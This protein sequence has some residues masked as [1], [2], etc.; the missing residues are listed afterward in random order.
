[1]SSARRYTFPAIAAAAALVAVS[2]V[3]YVVGGSDDDDTSAPL[4]SEPASSMQ[5]TGTTGPSETSTTATG[6]PPPPFVGRGELVA[7]VHDGAWRLDVTDRDRASV[8][9][10]V[11]SGGIVVTTPDGV[12]RSTNIQS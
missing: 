7:T 11:A 3:V 6:L 9:A 1:M 10:S 4:P 2:V 12:A 8:L 5:V